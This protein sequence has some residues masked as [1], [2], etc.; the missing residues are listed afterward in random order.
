MHIN[1]RQLQKREKRNFLKKKR[2]RKGHWKKNFYHPDA[3]LIGTKTTD[4]VRLSEEIMKRTVEMK[5][6]TL[7][8][9]AT[10][11]QMYE[12]VR[13]ETQNA[14]ESSKSG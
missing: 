1:Q 5:E 11:K 8:A 14:I 12:A 2:K 13:N 4:G 7:E 3:S 10:T 9:S 6:N